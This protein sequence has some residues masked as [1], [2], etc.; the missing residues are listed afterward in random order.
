MTINYKDSKRIVALS[1]DTTFDV[2]ATP[3]TSGVGSDGTTWSRNDTGTVTFSNSRLNV[4]SDADGTIDGC[5][6][7]LGSGYIGDT[8]TLDYDFRFST[9]SAGLG[10]YHAFMISNTGSS[11][12]WTSTSVNAIWAKAGAH[13]SVSSADNMWIGEAENEALQ[14]GQDG[15][16][17][18]SGN[19]GWSTNTTFYARLTRVSDTQYKFGL[20]SDESRTTLL[21][22]T[23]LVTG[24]I[25]ASAITDLRYISFN[26]YDGN[27]SGSVVGYFENIK[28]YNN[29][30]VVYGEV[31]SRPNDVQDNSI[32]VE[33]DTAR[34]YW[35]TDKVTTE[36]VYNYTTAPS[37]SNKLTGTPIGYSADAVGVELVSSTFAGKYIKTGKWMLK[38]VGTLGSNAFMKVQDSSGTVKATS[39]GVAASGIGTSAFEYVTF[40]LPTAV[41]LANGDRVY[42]EYTGADTSGDYLAIGEKHPSTTPTGWEYT[43]YNLR[44]SNG[45]NPSGAWGDDGL[46]TALV[47]TATFDSAPASNVTSDSITWTMQPTKQFDFSSSTGWVSNNS[48]F[49]ID[50]SIP[51]LIANNESGSDRQVGYDLTSIS[52]TAWVID[53]DLKIVSLTSAGSLWTHI[54]MFS[55]DTT[56]DDD[57]TQN[58]LGLILKAEDSQGTSS[59]ALHLADQQGGTLGSAGHTTFG[60]NS[61]NG[62]PQFYLR[63][64]RTASDKL[65]LENYS[66]SART[67]TPSTTVTRTLV[68]NPQ[69]L[70]YFKVTNRTAGGTSPLNIKIENLKIY[71]GVT[72]VN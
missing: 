50:T 19:G 14:E 17:W 57:Q 61:L 27:T 47:P 28:F 66:S 63:M 35:G 8:W 58:F 69:S 2:D 71:K 22:G 10:S 53:F 31:K 68:D 42:V 37:T 21:S 49:A 15:D 52:D 1:T 16:V 72:S 7:D 64:K 40:T 33:K 56:V 11:A 13:P 43:I 59:D 39:A 38:R 18:A 4:A 34:R 67:G 65:T 29:A 54:G 48:A 3:N 45:N 44:D 32:L 51:A 5:A 41:E 25:T 30:S 24:T 70:R 12:N 26:N 6:Y 62:T 36:E 23:Q 9:M 20:Y 55:V 60:E 46:P